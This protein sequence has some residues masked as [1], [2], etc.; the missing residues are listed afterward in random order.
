MLVACR[1]AGL[2]ALEAY[3]ASVGPGTQANDTGWAAGKTVWGPLTHRTA[4][5]GS[6][7]RASGLP[8]APRAGTG[9]L[10]LPRGSA[11]VPGELGAR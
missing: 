5:Q 6:R 11:P 2:S 4:V 9:V 1:L 7:Q 3:Y 8:L 10:S